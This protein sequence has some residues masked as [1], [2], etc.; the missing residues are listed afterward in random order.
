MMAALDETTEPNVLIDAITSAAR[1]VSY[2]YPQDE[3]PARAFEWWS[4]PCGGKSAKQVREIFDIFNLFGDGVSNFR[5]PKSIPKGSGRIAIPLTG[6]DQGR[7]ATRSP[8]G[9]AD[10]TSPSR[11]ST[12]HEE[13]GST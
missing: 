1:L 6:R 9:R 8:Q 5:K 3:D 12:S 13:I 7:T 2:V 4:S 11:W 10:A